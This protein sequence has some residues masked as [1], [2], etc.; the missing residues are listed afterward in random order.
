MGHS[1]VAGMIKNVGC[2]SCKFWPHSTLLSQNC[3]DTFLE[4]YTVNKH[5]N[6]FGTDES[7]KI[8]TLFL[9]KT[10]R[11]HEEKWTSILSGILIY[12]TEELV[13]VVE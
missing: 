8:T 6:N 4:I 5:L 3:G 10:E 11:G 13:Y 12:F 2:L 9:M 7:L 1:N